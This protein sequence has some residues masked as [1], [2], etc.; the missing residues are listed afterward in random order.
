MRRIIA[1]GI[2]L[3]FGLVAESAA[4]VLPPG[5]SESL[6][7][8]GI[9]SPTAMAF[10]PDGRLFVCQQG[11]QLRVIKDGDAASGAVRIVDRQRVRRAGPAGCCVRSELCRESI[12][13]RVLHGYNAHDS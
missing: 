3:L 1:T 13:V 4:A 11:G 10:A 8:S 5:F 2:L 6:V 7:A 12:R 9:S